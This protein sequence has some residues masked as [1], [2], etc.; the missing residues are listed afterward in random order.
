MVQNDWIVDVLVDLRAYAAANG[1]TTLVE[2]LDRTMLVALAEL[3]SEE[4]GADAQTDGK[5]DQSGQNSPG[6][7]SHQR[8]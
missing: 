5:Q 1:L 2:Q 6:L 8:A 7:R 3:A 4:H